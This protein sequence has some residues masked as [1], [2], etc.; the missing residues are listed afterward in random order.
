[1]FGQFLEIQTDHQTLKWLMTTAKLTGK[2]ARCALTLQK[3][4]FEIVHRPGT[5]NANA[6]GCSRCPLV[7]GEGDEEAIGEMDWGAFYNGGIEVD[8]R[9]G[10][11]SWDD[12]PRHWQEEEALQGAHLGAEENVDD[13]E[14]EEYSQLKSAAVF[15]LQ[16]AIRD[17]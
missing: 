15:T 3:Y 12:V 16:G 6:D 2:F 10:G 8:H 5:A 9:G 14:G 13:G 17:D 11:R 7:R 1:M 4:Y